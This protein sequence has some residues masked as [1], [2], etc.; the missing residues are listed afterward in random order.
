MMQHVQ[1]TLPSAFSLSH[2]NMFRVP[3]TSDEAIVH[4]KLDN[5]IEPVMQNAERLSFEF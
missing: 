3:G 1:S 5:V 2:A 4:K